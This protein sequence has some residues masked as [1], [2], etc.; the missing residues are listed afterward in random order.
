[1]VIAPTESLNCDRIAVNANAKTGTL[2]NPCKNKILH[3]RV[4]MV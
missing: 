4:K 3:P 2:R 1:M